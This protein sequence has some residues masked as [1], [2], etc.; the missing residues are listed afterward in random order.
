M[1]EKT[2]HSINPEFAFWARHTIADK[3]LQGFREMNEE[4]AFVME[5]GIGYRF[6]SQNGTDYGDPVIELG[7]AVKP[8]GRT[9][10]LVSEAYQLERDDEYD[11]HMI[12]SIDTEGEVKRLQ[13]TIP[14]SA[15]Y[16]KLTIADGVI[17]SKE[18]QNELYPDNEDF[19]GTGRT[20]VRLDTYDS[21]NQIQQMYLEKVGIERVRWGLNQLI[22]Q[23]R[24]SGVQ[25]EVLEKVA[26]SYNL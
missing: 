6:F 25:R 8:G 21:K 13:E 20:I 18:A 17:Y 14:G 15:M 26:S 3:V 24:L 22:E 1:S 7:G 23:G 2:P 16:A 4:G 9:D 10:K 19:S 12:V 11:P 5:E